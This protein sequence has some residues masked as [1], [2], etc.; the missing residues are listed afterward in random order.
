M[1]TTNHLNPQHLPTNTTILHHH[2][3]TLFNHRWQWQWPIPVPPTQGWIIMGNLG[4]RFLQN[5]K[6]SQEILI[7]NPTQVSQKCDTLKTT[8]TSSENFFLT[9]KN[10][11]LDRK[12]LLVYIGWIFIARVTTNPLKGSAPCVTGKNNYFVSQDKYFLWRGS[13]K[14]YSCDRKYP[15]CDAHSTPC[16]RRNILCHMMK[17]THV[18]KKTFL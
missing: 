14:N 18:T 11:S 17:Y 3:Y 2:H 13:L 6:A 15:S 4:T 10:S 8:Q 5:L 1:T 9:A 7:V 16:N 12:I